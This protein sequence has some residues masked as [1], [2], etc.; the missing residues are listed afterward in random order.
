MVGEAAVRQEELAAGGIRAERGKNLS[1]EE[2][3][4]AVARVH[5]D[6]EAGK[7]LL[8][9]RGGTDLFP[10]HFS[11]G[12]QEIC[13]CRRRRAACG[14]A[15][16]ARRGKDLRDVLLFKAALCGEEFEAVALK[17]QVACG[18]HDRA[19]ERPTFHH[20][21]HEHRRRGAEAEI[22]DLHP[23]GGKAVREPCGELFARKAG[24]PPDGNAFCMR[25]G[26]LFQPCRK[27]AADG[28]HGFFRQI[29]RLA[30]FHGNG[31]AADVA[32]VL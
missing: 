7:R 21:G 18:D 25:L 29:D 2:T 27:C 20:G 31:N 4:C 23:G 24:I 5:E 30:A 14:E 10:E 19:V 13:P 11:I 26:V 8:H 32:A 9:A 28:A 1:C 6:A 17:G 16:C 22:R 12:G 15:A 3:A